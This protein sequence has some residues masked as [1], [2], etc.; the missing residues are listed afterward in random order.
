MRLHPSF[1]EDA[2]RRAETLVAYSE[3]ESMCP[4]TGAEGVLRKEWRIRLLGDAPDVSYD[5]IRALLPSVVEVREQILELRYIRRGVDEGWRFHDCSDSLDEL[6]TCVDSR[7]V[8]IHPRLMEL[9]GQWAAAAEARQEADRVARQAAAEQAERQRKESRARNAFRRMTEP[10]ASA[11]VRELAIRWNDHIAELSADEAL[12]G[13]LWVDVDY[14]KTYDAVLAAET[15]PAKAKA[16]RLH[17]EA[18][19]RRK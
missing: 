8:A 4:E 9:R 7:A 10:E 14:R 1:V 13:R 5:A 16:I 12:V 19:S 17:L 2:R 3:R 18:W 15:V 11:R 6:L